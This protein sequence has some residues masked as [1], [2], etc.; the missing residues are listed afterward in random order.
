LYDNVAVCRFW[1]CRFASDLAG[2]EAVRLCVISPG[3]PPVEILRRLYIYVYI[4]THTHTHTYIY[5]CIY[6]YI[7]TYIHTYIYI[8]IHI[9]HNYI[10]RDINYMICIYRII[11]LSLFS[12]N[13]LSR[14]ER[15]RVVLS[16][17]ARSRCRYHGWR[18]GA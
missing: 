11:R 1:Q 4:Y 13:R 8:H 18:G 6:I 17:H 2:P 5:I 7:Y 16:V 9:S 15:H 12:S 3:S 14:S 10:V